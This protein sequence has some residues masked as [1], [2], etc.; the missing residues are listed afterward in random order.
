MAYVAM[1]GEG[2]AAQAALVETLT[3]RKGRVSVLSQTPGACILRDTN[4]AREFVRD[5]KAR[6]TS[7]KLM[8][9][10]LE[11]PQEVFEPEKEGAL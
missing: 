1:V 2:E 8:V 4:M 7:G 6:M 10:R 11:E 3:A 9:F 5:V